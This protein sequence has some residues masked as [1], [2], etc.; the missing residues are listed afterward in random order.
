MRVRS[1]ERRLNAEACPERSRRAQRGRRA[2]E[3]AQ[4]RWGP[5][6]AR[7]GRSRLSAASLNDV[8]SAV[9]VKDASFSV[10]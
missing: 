3:R 8:D 5:S 6:C 4:L 9:R 2:G 7:L 1:R 10:R